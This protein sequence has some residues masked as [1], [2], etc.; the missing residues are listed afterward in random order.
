M[1]RLLLLASFL[2]FWAVYAT[3]QS[4]EFLHSTGKRVEWLDR[5]CSDIEG[6]LYIVGR[7]GDI[8]S[9][10][11]AFIIRISPNG[12]TLSYTY[13]IEGNYSNFRDVAMLPNGN[14][15]VTGF[16]ANTNGDND[17]LL[18][19]LFDTELNVLSE[20]LYECVG[21]GTLFRSTS[22]VVLDS[23]GNAVV[24]TSQIV[25]ESGGLRRFPAILYR[26]NEEDLK[27]LE[28]VIGS[29]GFAAPQI[30]LSVYKNRR[31][32]YKGIYLWCK[33]DMGCCRL[34]P[35]FATTWG[36]ELI[37]IDNLQIELE[38]SAF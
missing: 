3:A 32:R 17:R 34:E 5:S 35:Q 28:K 23:D 1:K 29:S 8:F 2:S 26:F 13:K 24:F 19:V 11:D 14:L 9:H 33:A 16:R 12:D 38:E 6:N 27:A 37:K 30:K 15:F 7:T 10:S 36:Y 22:E 4:W 21:Q 25:P 20:K 31:G 18:V